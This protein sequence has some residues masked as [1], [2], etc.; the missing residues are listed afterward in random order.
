M[1]LIC[2][3][4]PI[5]YKIKK[6]IGLDCNWGVPIAVVPPC[7][8]S[9]KLEVL[10]HENP[11]FHKINIILMM[12]LLG[13]EKTRYLFKFYY[14]GAEEYFGS[15]R[16]PNYLTIEDCLLTALQEKNYM[17][18][19]KTS[20][21]EVASRTD[22]FVSARGSTFSF[23]TEK[24]PILMEINS[25]LPKNI[26]VWAYSKVPTDFY[27]RYNAQFRHY[28]YIMPYPKAI[29]KD[30]SI[31]NMKAMEKVC[32]ALEGR[33]NFKNFSKQGKE[34]VKN[35][36]DMIATSINTEGNFIIFDFKSRAFLRQQIRRMVA[37][38][39]EV[40]FGKTSYEEFIDLFDPSKDISYQPAD[41]FG[42]ILWDIN[43]GNNVSFV[44]DNKSKERRDK[45]FREQEQNFSLKKKL[46]NF[47][48][49]NNIG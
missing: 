48:Q 8:W 14:I 43:Y 37:K 1:S 35:V 7:S 9:V 38:I 2:S 4:I 29:L 17:H 36:R 34:K 15:Q 16:Q 44:I 24:T 47:M 21:F 41:P 45:Y 18:E 25:A 33:H 28:K 11:F 32:K 31:D 6:K 49:H 39:L 19:A 42:L 46:F 20:G 5:S 40:G 30:D 27:S 22:K 12:K 10:F 26:G 23:I 3:K 13:M